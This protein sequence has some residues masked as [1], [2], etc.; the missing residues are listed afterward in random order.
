MTVAEQ[1]KPGVRF[2]GEMG[3]WGDW[4]LGDLYVERNEQGNEE[5]PMLSVSIYDGISDGELDEA[6]LGKRVRRSA[7]KTLYKRV[8]EGDVVLNMMR[9]WQGAI[10]VS[11]TEGMVSPA[12][13]TAQPNLELSSRFMDHAL[14][15]GQ[16]VKQ[17][18]DLSYG[19]TDFR[20]RLY[21]DSFERVRLS[22]PLVHE[23][24]KIG[25]LFE[26]LDESIELH[27]R[28]LEKLRQFKQ[29]MLGK[30]F[31]KQSEDI[32]EIRFPGFAEAWNYREFG[33]TFGAIK[34]RSHSRAE[35]NDVLG[36]VST[37]HYG[38]ILVKYQALVDYS[39][40]SLPFI[41]GA[42]KGEFR[43]MLL[44]EGDVLIADA[45]ED[46]SVG[47]AVEIVELNEKA[48]IAGL[49]TIACRPLRKFERGYLGYFLNSAVFHNQLLP[50]MQGTKV[51]SLSRRAMATTQVWYPSL[52]EQQKIGEFF[53]NLDE[54]IAFQ[55]HKGLK[56]AQVKHALLDGMF[57]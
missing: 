26:S 30:M 24:Q 27:R 40:D 45:A 17:M 23:Q 20:K 10:G 22:L 8:Y 4:S 19:V 35:L 28:Q 42:S 25:A 9:A 21:W 2:P 56:L 34:N 36:E 6:A 47:A 15:R 5:L 7:D 49:H 12:Y 54:L 41:T 18:N 14:R 51:L 52:A 32:P 53:A 48:V 46:S 55:A 43:G 57:V 3:P 16:V 11:R 38:D 1:A 37:I 31:P 44:E 50:L 33:D 39:R 13:I 29:T